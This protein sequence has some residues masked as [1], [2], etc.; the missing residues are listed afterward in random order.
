MSVAL[1]QEI[2]VN[3]IVCSTINGQ[4]PS[5]PPSASTTVSGSVILASAIDNAANKSKVPTAGQIVSYVATN[6]GGGGSVS[7]ATT[8]TAGIVTLASAIDNAG[9]NSNVPTAGQIVS[10]VA[11][12]GGGGSNPTIVDN[13]S[14]TILGSILI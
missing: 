2:R 7:A 8:T 6:G 10:Y 12:N 9:N 1:G 13:S 3:N 11:S 14:F 4:T 5:V